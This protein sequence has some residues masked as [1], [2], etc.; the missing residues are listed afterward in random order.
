[1]IALWCQVALLLGMPC[2][3]LVVKISIAHALGQV[4]AQ[5]PQSASDSLN[6]LSVIWT[7]GFWG[8]VVGLPVLALILGFC[9]ILPGTHRKKMA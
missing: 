5:S 6:M 7:A 1:M 8:F 3:Y 2:S 4:Q 9:G